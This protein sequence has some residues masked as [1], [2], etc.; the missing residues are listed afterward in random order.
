[1]LG[2]IYFF[3]SFLLSLFFFSIFLIVSAIRLEKYHFRDINLAKY[4]FLLLI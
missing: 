2:S 1:M 3:L 4:Y